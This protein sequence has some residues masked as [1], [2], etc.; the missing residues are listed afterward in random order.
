MTDYLMS[1]YNPIP[2]SL[3]R[4]EGVWVWDENGKKYLDAYAGIAV[5]NLGHSHPQVMAALEVGIHQVL[6]TSNIM[7]IS[8]QK[9]LAH[10][11]CTMAH[12]DRAFFCNSGAEANE[13]AI[14]LA[15]L[16]GH[17]KNISNPTIVAMQNSFHGR[18]LATLSASGNTKIH[19]GFE[20]LVD[21][22]TY[23]PYNDIPALQRCAQSNP[24]IVAVMLEP[25]QGEGG[26]RVIEDGYLEKI[27]ALCDENGWLMIL[28]EVQTGIGRTGAL[29][30]YQ[31]TSILPDIVA[32]AKG[33]GNGIPIG[34]CLARG[35][36]ANLFQVGNHGS[37]FG[38]NP[39]CCS[40]ANAVLSTLEDGKIYTN[41]LQMGAYLLEML[42]KE[43]GNI[44]GV[45]E[46]RG[47]G[48]MIGLELDRPC[49]PMLQLAADEGLLISVTSEKVIRLVPPLI[50]QK[51]HADLIVTTLAKTIP[52]FLRQSQP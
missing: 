31:H 12:M 4:G 50:L 49:R 18:T 1:T 37:T 6:H 41:V 23:I 19:K 27:R 25:V 33:L 46:V 32:S 47:R 20:P 7:T 16:Y 2:V 34:A 9:Q 14:K 43:L 3:T 10:R 51:E 13:T 24:N 11:F 42:K 38:G 28:D 30:A 5:T 36:A 29:F 22:F 39:L 17:Q 45:V 40:V 35:I 44:P 21:G 15:R 26:I 52:M 48:L 8:A